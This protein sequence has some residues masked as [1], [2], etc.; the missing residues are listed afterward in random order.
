MSI[1][2]PGQASLTGS[3]RTP[4][5]RGTSQLFGVDTMAI[6]PDGNFLY[7][8]NPTMSGASPIIDVI[9]LRTMTHVKQIGTPT[10]YP[11]PSGIPSD[12]PDPIR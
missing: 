3:M 12:P 11:D 9:D 10:N 2:G 5:R 1:T 8:T 4:S 7:V 6:T